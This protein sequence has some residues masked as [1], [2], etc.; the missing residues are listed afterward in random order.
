MTNQRVLSTLP[1]DAPGVSAAENGSAA[2]DTLLGQLLARR[3]LILAQLGETYLALET[4]RARA[5]QCV[6][7]IQ[8]LRAALAD[9]EQTFQGRA[10]GVPDPSEAQPSNPSQE[11]ERR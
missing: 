11:M 9:L 10:Q 6:A 2:R 5:E 8:N 4:H 7:H 1:L 3:Q